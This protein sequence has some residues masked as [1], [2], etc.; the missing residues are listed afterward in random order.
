[1]VIED[2]DVKNAHNTNTQPMYHN[3]YR[4]AK[5]QQIVSTISNIH[6]AVVY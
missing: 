6:I 2:R 3:S 4:F 5:Q 1:M